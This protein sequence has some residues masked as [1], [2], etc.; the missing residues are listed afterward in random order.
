MTR[1]GPLQIYDDDKFMKVKPEIKR[2]TQFFIGCYQEKK[3]SFTNIKLD[4]VVN[5][6]LHSRK[7][8]NNISQNINITKFNLI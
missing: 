4:M 2:D 5:N 6:E 1:T 3:R 8:V 7:Y